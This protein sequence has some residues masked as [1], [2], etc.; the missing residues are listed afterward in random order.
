MSVARE[1]RRM[2]PKNHGTERTRSILDCL[3]SLLLL[4]VLCG[5]PA[6]RRLWLDLGCLPVSLK[7][8][9]VG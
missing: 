9:V 7:R 5:R 6:W 3:E 8:A 1:K 4:V 2:H